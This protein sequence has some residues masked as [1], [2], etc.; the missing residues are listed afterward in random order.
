M[1][2]GV[3]AVGLVLLNLLLL[4]C[5]EDNTSVAS[6]NTTQPATTVAISPAT[7]TLTVAPPTATSLPPTTLASLPTVTP[8][9]T[10]RPPVQ[11]TAAPTT[12]PATTPPVTTAAVDTPAQTTETVSP[13]AGKLVYANRDGQIIL[14][15]PD[16]NGR[17]QL[18][19][20]ASPIFSPDGKRVA[21]VSPQGKS[22]GEADSEVKAAIVSV[23]LSGGD[24]QTLCVT[25]ANYL[26]RLL[27]WSPRNRFIA[28]TYALAN[29]DSG[30]TVNLC[31]VTDG[32]TSRPLGASGPGVRDFYD[33]TPDGDNSIWENNP[34]NNEQ[35]RLFY[36]DP[37]KGGSVATALTSGQYLAVG[38]F[39][40]LLY[41]DARFAPDGKTVAVAGT[42][43]FF[44]S[45]PG[46]RSPLD[47]KTLNSSKDTYLEHL[48]WS[49]D[50]RTLAFLERN[51]DNQ[52]SRLVKVAL[53]GSEPSQPTSLAND[54]GDYFTGGLDWSK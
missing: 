53:T 15:N 31:N 26:L 18:G 10:T 46:Q 37:D 43:I 27:R 19:K 39:G 48:A 16:G 29:S 2:S 34:S 47:G 1:K 17:I 20:G 9:P 4:A 36:G 32:T 50:S 7:Q 49:P 25:K 24:R 41:R 6:G 51:Q 11:T 30:S 52:S 42:T 14:M 5:G 22:V 12:A 21:F 33:W 3:V 40:S 28:F 23:N 54:A 35:Y 13:G 44:V 45:A 8:L 38:G